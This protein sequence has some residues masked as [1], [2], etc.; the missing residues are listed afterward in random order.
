VASAWRPFAVAATL[1]ALVLGAGLFRAHQ[2][3]LDALATGRA[4]EQRAAAHLE[5]AAEAG[6]RVTADATA[7]SVTVPPRER[8]AGVDELVIEVGAGAEAIELHFDCTA[9]AP[10]LFEDTT[11]T[12]RWITLARRS[13]SGLPRCR[14]RLPTDLAFEVG[15]PPRMRWRRGWIPSSWCFAGRCPSPSEVRG[16]SLVYT[17]GAVRAAVPAA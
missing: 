11:G 1:A 3:H 10:V 8:G 6:A 2:D 15:R 16:P 14:A 4:A 13:T 7:V 5:L 12:T 17:D 9:G